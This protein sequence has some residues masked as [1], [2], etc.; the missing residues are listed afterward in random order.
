MTG[1]KDYYDTVNAMLLNATN[2]EEALAALQAIRN[3][4]LGGGL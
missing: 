4:L 2:R 3:A 1:F